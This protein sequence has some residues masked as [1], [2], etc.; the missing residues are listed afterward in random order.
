MAWNGSGTFLRVHNWQDDQANSIKILPD[1]HDAEDDNLAAG[2]S[3]CMPRDG[4]APAT[5]NQNMGDNRITVLAEPASDTDAATKNYVDAAIAAALAVVDSVPIGTI[6]PF[7]SVDNSPVGYLL[8]DGQEVNRTGTYAALFAVIGTKFGPGN[9]STTFNVPD[10]IGRHVE[11]TNNE[12]FVGNELAAEVGTHNH[13]ATGVVDNHAHS[14][15]SHTHAIDHDHPSFDTALGGS[16]GHIIT[17]FNYAA[18]LYM[19]R[20][21]GVSN[22]IGAGAA[23]NIGYGGGGSVDSYYAHPNISGINSAHA[24]SIDV[25]AF[26]GVSGAWAGSTGNFQPATTITVNA[27]AGVNR[28]ASTYIPYIIKY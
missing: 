26:A 7:G 13:T 21:R 8:C 11:G 10:L 17:G 14:V 1:R 2:F 4:Q 16:H 27:H 22:V 5:G 20:G 28:P 15:P 24:H 18:A 9:G 6:M 3:N 12:V 23:Q 25:P 19:E